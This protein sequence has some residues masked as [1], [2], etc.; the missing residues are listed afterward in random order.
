[1]YV[2]YNLLLQWTWTATI[3]QSSNVAW[4]YEV[5]S[6]FWYASGATTQVLVYSKL[7][8]I[9]GFYSPDNFNFNH[10][11]NSTGVKL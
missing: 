3:L 4:K 1:M 9:A 11:F 5:S 2:L 6:P 8:G 10:T 7:K